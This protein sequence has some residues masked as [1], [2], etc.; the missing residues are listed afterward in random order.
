MWCQVCVNLIIHLFLLSPSMLPAIAFSYAYVPSTLRSICHIL[1][2]C[3]SILHTCLSSS[4][5][6]LLSTCAYA[7]SC[8]NISL[9]MCILYSCFLLHV[10]FPPYASVSYWYICI[11]ECLLSI[12][13]ANPWYRCMFMP[14]INIYL[15][16]PLHQCV[17]NLIQM[18]FLLFAS[19]VN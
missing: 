4:S 10:P 11:N 7:F 2:P 6:Y 8:L 17:L 15:V 5:V 18:A 14:M 13:P 19:G 16:S 1:I 9:P 3:L 12:T